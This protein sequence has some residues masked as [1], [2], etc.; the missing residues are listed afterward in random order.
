YALGLS[1]EKCHGDP[2]AHV[3]YQTSHPA[4]TAGKYI[5]NPARFSRDR[6]V[7]N[8]A[9]CHS[10]ERDAKEPPFTYRPGDD[11]DDY[12]LPPSRGDEIVVEVVTGPVGKGRFL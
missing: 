4:D 3:R 2:R 11:L 12:F 10:G 7:D 1:C 8:C 6:Q 5:L 9:L